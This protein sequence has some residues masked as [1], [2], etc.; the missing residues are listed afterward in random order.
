MY[1]NV[2]PEHEPLPAGA[3]DICGE[4]GKHLSGCLDDPSQQAFEEMSYYKPWPLRI[5]VRQAPHP[6]YF[7]FWPEKPK[8]LGEWFWVSVVVGIIANVI[9][10]GEVLFS[11]WRGQW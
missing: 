9:V 11:F 8:P 2:D 3:C 4:K 7:G 1:Q 10:W 6:M 5:Q